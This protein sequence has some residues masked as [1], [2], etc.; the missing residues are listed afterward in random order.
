MA[1]QGVKISTDTHTRSGSTMVNTPWYA[2]NRFPRV[3]LLHDIAS[4]R[5]RNWFSSLNE[6]EAWNLHEWQWN[7]D[8]WKLQM[9]A[10]LRNM[11]E[12]TVRR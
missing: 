8:I 12:H 7:F 6:D 4:W 10:L 3:I 11:K 2:K 5:N 1:L 9:N